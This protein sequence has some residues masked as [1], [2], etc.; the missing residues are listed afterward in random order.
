[1]IKFPR[2]G[3]EQL[4]EQLVGFGVEKHDDLADAFSLLIN[5]TLNKHS[6]EGT[7]IMFWL[8]GNDNDDDTIYHSDYVD[9]EKTMPSNK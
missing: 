6:N 8:G 4:I 2:H 7:I 5:S 9:V 1:M 3:C